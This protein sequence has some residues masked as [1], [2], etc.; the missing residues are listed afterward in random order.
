MFK[1]QFSLDQTQARGTNLALSVIILGPRDHIK[2]LINLAHQCKIISS[3]SG[4]CCYSH[5]T[6][7]LLGFFVVVV[8]GLLR[9]DLHK[10]E[11]DRLQ[12]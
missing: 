1:S 10:K 8:V 9:K 2:C 12:I 7:I 11:L 5:S 3:I 6:Y 4:V